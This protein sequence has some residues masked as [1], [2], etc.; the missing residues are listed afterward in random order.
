MNLIGITTSTSEGSVAVALDDLHL[1]EAVF[2]RE[3]EHARRLAPALRDMLVKAGVGARHM[4][5]IG[6]DVG[7]GS[8]TGLRVGIATAQMVA[9]AFGAAL[10]GVSSLDAIAQAIPP[11]ADRLCA[12]LDARWGKVYACLYR[13]AKSGWER[14]GEPFLARVE[15][16]LDKIDGRTAVTGTG[17]EQHEE[18]VRKRTPRI[19]TKELWHPRAAR[20]ASIARTRFN[21]GERDLPEKLMPVYCV[22]DK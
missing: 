20:V 19:A 8:Y 10:I 4:D 18:A 3:T 22:G 17:L 1:E 11:E 9:M 16:V 5:A 21:A 13:P 14:D 2:T 6:V 15:N 12:M 7:P